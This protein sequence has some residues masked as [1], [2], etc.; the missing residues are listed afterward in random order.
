[1]GQLNIII[2]DGNAS[3]TNVMMI[4]PSVIEI[5]ESAFIGPTGAGLNPMRV[6]QL[7]DCKTSLQLNTN[8]VGI[9]SNDPSLGNGVR[10]PDGGAIPGNGCKPGAG[11]GVGTLRMSTCA[12]V[13]TTDVVNSVVKTIAKINAVA[14][15]CDLFIVV[16]QRVVFVG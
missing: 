14:C 2:G 3:A 8:R 15:M 7:I 9:P 16:D 6:H 4:C 1:M 5:A 10:A 12:V 13:V 11:C